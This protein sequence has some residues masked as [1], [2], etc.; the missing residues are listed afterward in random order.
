MCKIMFNLIFLS[1]LPNTV[2]VLMLT[3]ERHSPCNNYRRKKRNL[4][5]EF[6]SWTSLFAFH[7]ELMPL[8][9]VSS[10]KY[11]KIIEHAWECNQ[12][13]RRKILNSNQLYFAQNLTLC[14]IPTVSKGLGN[15]ILSNTPTI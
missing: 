7:L 5:S 11:E 13:K 3:H 12:S 6:E 9:K 8:G 10:S 14:D 15:D 2:F 4:Q 1:V